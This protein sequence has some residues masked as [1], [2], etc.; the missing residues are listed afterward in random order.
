LAINLIVGG[1]RWV[2]GGGQRYLARTAVFAGEGEINVFRFQE[3]FV[4]AEV[5]QN[6]VGGDAGDADFEEEIRG[7]AGPGSSIF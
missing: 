4:A 2:V 5:T 3:V 6:G 7:C 1:G